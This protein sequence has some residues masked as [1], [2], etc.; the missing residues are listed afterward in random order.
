MSNTRER[1]LT[2]A[3][4]RLADTLV[5]DYDV[6]DLLQ[7]LVDTTAEVLRAAAA[8]LVL[9]DEHGEL[10]VVAS[11]SEGDG[12][13]NLMQPESGDGPAAESYLS[14]E[15]YA[16]ADLDSLDDRTFADAASV[17]GFRSLHSVPMRLRGRTIGALTLF[18][19]TVGVLSDDDAT[20]VRGLA[21]V[22]T[23]GILHERAL[24]ESGLV[25]QQLQNAL[26]SRVV[27]EQAKGVVA[28]TRSVDMDSA[29]R[30]LRDY[31]RSN[32][33]NLRDVAELVVSRSISI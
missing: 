11:T 28:Q 31:A 15:P 26:S 17:L 21:D 20:V 23:I 2:A 25:Q 8:G 10:S 18:R 3:F 9:A 22:A 14:G 5:D 19:S 7:T 13:V 16:V 12:V 27:I 29:F 33:L 24:R 1:S 4:V 6:V 30:M 32:H